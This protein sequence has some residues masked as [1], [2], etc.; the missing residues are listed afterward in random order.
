MS[1]VINEVGFDTLPQGGILNDHAYCC[2]MDP[3]V[4]KIP[5]EYPTERLDECRDYHM[6]TVAQRNQDAK[7]LGVPLFISEFGMC[8]NN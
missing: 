6:R 7:K 3:E 5:G 2:T 1:G 4:C 8:G